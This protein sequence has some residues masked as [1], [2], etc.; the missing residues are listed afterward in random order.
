MGIRASQTAEL[1]FDN[2]RVPRSNLVGKEGQ[3]FKIAMIGLDGA[4]I[5]IA[6][7]ALGLAEGA[8]EESVNYMKER[9]Q[10]GKPI[11]SFQGLQWYISDMATKIECAKWMIY[12]A[13]SLKIAGKPFTKEA[14]MAKLNAAETASLVTNKALQIHGGYGYMKDYPLERMLRDAKITEIYEG[15]SEIHKVVISRAVLG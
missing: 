10:F 14:A 4:R 7:Q 12:R 1:I 6:A 13:A 8:L 9:V 15:T 2:C 3:G 11:A 5:G